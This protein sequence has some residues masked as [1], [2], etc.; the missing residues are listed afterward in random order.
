[1]LPWLKRDGSEKLEKER[2]KKKREE[3][4]TLGPPP[5]AFPV[6]ILLQI[7]FSHRIY[8]G[9]RDSSLFPLF[10]RCFRFISRRPELV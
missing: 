7:R 4:I 10:R 6:Y 8:N 5:L 3:D 9:W 2:K 1:M